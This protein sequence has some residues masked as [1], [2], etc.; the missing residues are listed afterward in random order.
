MHAGLPKE[1][2]RAD[3]PFKYILVLG[4]CIQVGAH[5]TIPHHTHTHPTL[6][7][8]SHVEQVLQ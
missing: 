8:S 2:G 6:Y 5:H 7:R 4:K 3:V 1:A